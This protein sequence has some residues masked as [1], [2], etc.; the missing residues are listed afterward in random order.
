MLKQSDP[1][2]STIVGSNVKLKGT[3]KDT[4]DIIVHGEVDGEI[5]C[6]KTVIITESA[7]VKGPIKAEIITVGGTVKGAIEATTKLELLPSGKIEGSISTKDLIIQ[8]GATFNGKAVMSQDQSKI[9]SS[10]EKEDQPA[11][12]E[13]EADQP[14]LSSKDEPEIE[15]ELED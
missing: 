4:A 15:F 14:N 3:L 8:S 2:Q 11:N 12:K 9:D 13:A 1:S 7:L 10:Q 5:I 6:D